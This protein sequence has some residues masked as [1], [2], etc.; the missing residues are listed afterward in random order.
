M[1]FSEGLGQ[2]STHPKISV[3]DRV[4]VIE[5]GKY[6]GYNLAHLKAESRRRNAC[7]APSAWWDRTDLFEAAASIR[8]RFS[9]GRIDQLTHRATGD[10]FMTQATQRS[11]N[12][13]GERSGSSRLAA[14]LL[15]LTMAVVVSLSVRADAPKTL[16]GHEITERNKPGVIMINSVWQARLGVW[17][18]AIKNS[19]ALEMSIRRQARAGLIAPNDEGKATLQEIAKH[20]DIYLTRSGDGAIERSEIKGQGTGFIITPDG[21]IVTNDHVV[22]M[23]KDQLISYVANKVVKERSDALIRG[24]AAKVELP[25]DDP[26]RADLIKAFREYFFRG[27]GNG[28]GIKVIDYDEKPERITASIPVFNGVTTTVKELECDVRKQGEPTPGKDVAI[29]KVEQNKLPT[30][31]VGDDSTLSQGDQIYVMGFPG[32]HP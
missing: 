18:P 28:G 15:M 22:S 31:P 26:L 3:L 12:G 10:K 14:W 8:V 16:S 21:Y 17:N 27:Y 4:I 11:R 23:D 13:E 32:R 7:L 29:L 1:A 5:S 24:L 2:V 30:V 25:D 6:L 9:L 20:P 19:A